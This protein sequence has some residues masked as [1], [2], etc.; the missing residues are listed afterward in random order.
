MEFIRSRLVERHTTAT[1]VIEKDLGVNALSHLIITLDGLNVTDEA[2][3]AEVLAFINNVQVTRLGQTVVDLQS[4]DLYGI[5][6]YLFRSLPTLTGRLATDNYTRSLTLIVPF[7]RTIMNAAECYP[8]QKK[9]ELTLRLDTTVPS[10]SLDG[11]TV[12]VDMVELVDASPT[13]Y[14]KT[15][16]RALSAPGATGEREHEL[17][18]GNK[19]VMCQFRLTTVPTTSSHTFGVDVVKLLVDN[20]EYGYAAADMMCLCGERMLR[21][22][23]PDATIAAQGLSPLNNI[24]WMDFDPLGNDEFLVDTS[25]YTSVKLNL[26]MGVDEATNLTVMELV[27]A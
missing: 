25:Q 22:G 15:Y 11:S 4:E 14:I 27:G 8:A 21:V 3:L 10:S 2:T 7:G 23:C 17:S 26:D 18:L 12:S 6:A 24:A 20:R 19:L 1:E 13:Q 5:N 16:R 9:G